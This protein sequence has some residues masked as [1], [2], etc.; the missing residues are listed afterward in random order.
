M[1]HCFWIHGDD[2]DADYWDTQCGEAFTLLEGTPLENK[3]KFCPYCG[4][5]LVEEPHEKD[6]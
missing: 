4:R 3:M 5:K 2:W 1:E 6:S